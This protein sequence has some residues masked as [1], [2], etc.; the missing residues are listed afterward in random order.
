MPSLGPCCE[1]PALET[2]KSPTAHVL[3]VSKETISYKQIYVHR[4][5]LYWT[6]RGKT[7]ARRRAKLCSASTA[8]PVPRGGSAAPKESAALVGYLDIASGHLPGSGS[9][10]R[11]TSTGKIQWKKTHIENALM[12]PK[13]PLTLPRNAP[14][15]R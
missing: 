7:A 8:L 11:E 10:A 13:T 9:D 15:H 1:E 3:L 12:H 5:P 6:V 14:K 4:G 2:A